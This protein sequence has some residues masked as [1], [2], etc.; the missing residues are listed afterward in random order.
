MARIDFWAGVAVATLVEA[1][2][3]VWFVLRCEKTALQEMRDMRALCTK[4]VNE[5]REATMMTVEGVI[6]AS[7]VQFAAVLRDR[8]TW[9]KRSEDWEGQFND[10]LDIVERM[11]QE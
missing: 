5:M 8:D 11:R 7:K 4:T 10:A 6:E 9:R 1:P 2:I 3:F